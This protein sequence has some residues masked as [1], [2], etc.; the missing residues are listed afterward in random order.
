VY[1]TSTY[2]WGGNFQGADGVYGQDGSGGWVAV[3]GNDTT[4]GGW[5]GYFAGANGIYGQSSSGYAGQFD[6]QNT[7]N[8]VD[9]Y[10]NYGNA[11]LC[12]NGQCATTLPTT[13]TIHY[14]PNIGAGTVLGPYTFCSMTGY[15]GDAT[16][17]RLALSS[18]SPGAYYF[19]VQAQTG[20]IDAMCY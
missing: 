10:N 15:G 20:N 16:S 17:Q 14:F 1:G 19:Q 3:Y 7:Q 13:P 9:I 4:G 5:G 2:G 8:G 11:Q 18:G 6:S 12:L